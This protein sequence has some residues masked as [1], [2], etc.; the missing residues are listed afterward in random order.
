MVSDDYLRLRQTL[1]M[2]LRPFPEA[3]R[4]VAAELHR[5]EDEIAQG[6]LT[7]A[8]GRPAPHPSLAVTDIDPAPA[9]P[10]EPGWMPARRSNPIQGHPLPLH[11]YYWRRRSI[12]ELRDLGKKL[13]VHR[14]TDIHRLQEKLTRRVSGIE[15]AMA[16]LTQAVE[17][18]DATPDAAGQGSTHREGPAPPTPR[19]RGRPRGSS[20]LPPIPDAA[21][22]TASALALDFARALDPD[23]DRPRHRARPTRRVAIQTD[24]R[25]T[26][27]V[28]VL[29]RP[30]GRQNRLRPRCAPSTP[31]STRHRQ[32]SS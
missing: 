14:A 22:L 24:R 26:K 9:A 1:I 11:A 16:H 21:E 18:L 28:V 19:P 17:I 15:Q 30:P 20:Y 31:L 32:Q 7:A 8:A 12:A 2:A 10:Q 6:V 25:P 3:R 23:L 29:L 13:K 5:I 27:A 4:A